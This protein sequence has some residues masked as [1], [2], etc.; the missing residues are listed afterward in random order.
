MVE[1]EVRQDDVQ[2]LY[3][4]EQRGVLD[5]VAD[6]GSGIDHEELRALPDHRRA[7]L[8]PARRNPA[9]AAEQRQRPATVGVGRLGHL[10]P[11]TAGA[12]SVSSTA[13]CGSTPVTASK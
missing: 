13:G 2:R 4:L 7:R 8:A 3:P 1:M 11:Q 6:P 12:T 5:E 10:L 9:A